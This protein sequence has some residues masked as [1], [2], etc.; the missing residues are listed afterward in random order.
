MEKGA[1][2][3]NTMQYIEYLAKIECSLCRAKVSVD[4]IRTQM[5]R[6]VYWRQVIGGS[7]GVICGYCAHNLFSEHDKVEEGKTS[8]TCSCGITI[9]ASV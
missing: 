6:G 7:G 3:I 4:T 1:H 8:G 2:E 9:Q 5:M